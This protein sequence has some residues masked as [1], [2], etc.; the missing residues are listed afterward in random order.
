MNLKPLYIRIFLLLLAFLTQ[1]PS[2]AQD[3]QRAKSIVDSLCAPYMNGRGYTNQ[4]DKIAANFIKNQFEAAGL[5]FF[6]KG[7]FHRFK[8]D[9]NTFGGNMELK[10]GRKT[11]RP[12]KDYIAHP[13]SPKANGVGKLLYLDSAAIKNPTSK[14]FKIKWESTIL[15]YEEKY[16]TDLYKLPKKYVALFLK[17]KAH[18]L[19][20]DKLTYWVSRSQHQQAK[21]LVLKEAFNPS[22]KKVNF[23]IDAQVKY[24]YQSQNVVAY[25][26]GK[27]QPDSFMVFTAH[28][29]HLGNMGANT[30]F[31]G[32]NDNA[33]GVAMLI[34]LANYYA[35]NP[36]ACSVAF[37]AFSAEEAGLVGSRYYTESPFFPLKQIKFLINL[38]LFATGEKGMTAVNGSVYKEAFALLEQINQ[39]HNYLPRIGKRGEAANSDHYF[40]YKENVPCFFF[41]LE[42]DWKH[43]HDVNDTTPIPF[44]KFKEAFLLIRDFTNQLA[45]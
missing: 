22:A 13:A 41:Y 31:P 34:E 8:L 15:A 24:G 27:S 18:L 38:D 11:L 17:A 36:P 19:I 26:E 20:V 30:F 4:G 3:L 9:V 42:G 1:M 23:T 12:G 28:Y 7:P 5:T 14:L 40:F 29:D 21:L 33:S 16:A 45:K 10:L 39:T 37:I 35:K 32:A 2:K 44:S 25:I 6:G 43:Y